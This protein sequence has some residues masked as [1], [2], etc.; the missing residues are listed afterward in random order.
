MITTFVATPGKTVMTLL[1]WMRRGMEWLKM[2][3]KLFV[4]DWQI[5]RRK[6][7][8]RMMRL[9]AWRQPWPI[10]FVDSTPWRWTKIM[11]RSA[12]HHQDTPVKH[13]SSLQ[14]HHPRSLSGDPCLRSWVAPL[15]VGHPTARRRREEGQHDPVEGDLFSTTPTPLST[16]TTAVSPPT[17][18]TM[19]VVLLPGNIPGIFI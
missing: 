14:H 9:F 12:L 11:L 15:T 19:L 5:W 16:L 10:V 8:F 17:T 13:N 3:M 1:M 18:T 2:R 7:I 6:S 4:I